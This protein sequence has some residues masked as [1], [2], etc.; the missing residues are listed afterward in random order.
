VTK[1]SKPAL[2]NSMEQ[3]VE[4]RARTDGNGASGP[5]GLIG[6]EKSLLPAR[7]RGGAMDEYSQGTGRKSRL[8]D[9]ERRDFAQRRQGRQDR[10]EEV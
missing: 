2:S 8:L 9:E 4:T 5:F 3:F 6:M 7:Q 10:K 1:N